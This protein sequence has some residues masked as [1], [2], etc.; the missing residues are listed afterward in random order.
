MGFTA[1]IGVI[2]PFA[3][4]AQSS[5]PRPATASTQPWWIIFN[6]AVVMPISFFC[7]ATGP[8]YIFGAGGRDV[9]SARNRARAGL[10]VDD[11]FR[12][13]DAQ[14]LIGGAILI[15]ALVAHSLWQLADGRRRKAVTAVRHPA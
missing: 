13:A 4:A 7:L 10:G 15:V 14:R 11:L 5:L 1:L 12:G 2:F 6:G 9:L 8:R 3:V